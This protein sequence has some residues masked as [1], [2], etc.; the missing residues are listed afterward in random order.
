[1]KLQMPGSSRPADVGLC[2]STNIWPLST[3]TAA[4][5]GKHFFN[6]FNILITQ[7]IG[8]HPPPHESRQHWHLQWRQQMT[9]RMGVPTTTGCWQ[10]RHDEANESPQRRGR[11][12]GSPPS[13]TMMVSRKYVVIFFFHLIIFNVHVHPCQSKMRHR[14]GV[15]FIRS[16][17]T[18]PPHTTTWQWRGSSSSSPPPQSCNVATTT[19][20]PTPSLATVS[21]ARPGWALFFHFICCR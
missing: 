12:E 18:H 2:F 8:Q 7:Y 14:G 11:G 19:T 6:W 15:F 17:P 21:Q 20:M 10:Q 1:M 4:T 16:Q 5:N 9:N 13:L 3:S